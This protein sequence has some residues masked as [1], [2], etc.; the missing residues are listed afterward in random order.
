MSS[1]AGNSTHLEEKVEGKTDEEE[2]VAEGLMNGSRRRRS[3]MSKGKQ[4]VGRM[5]SH[6]AHFTGYRHQVTVQKSNGE[7][8]HEDES[9]SRHDRIESEIQA[10][11]QM[12]ADSVGV[13][14]LPA[15]SDI[16]MLLS[17]KTRGSLYTSL[18][19]LVQGRN[20]VLLYRFGYIL[21]FT[22]RNLPVF[23]FILNIT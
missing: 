12:A 10:S 9:K 4:S 7:V 19:A 18:P 14:N 13:Q 17:E 11:T 6:A 15:C 22:I 21:F 2:S 3:L 23:S 8:Q 20:W 5:I 1:A 16:S